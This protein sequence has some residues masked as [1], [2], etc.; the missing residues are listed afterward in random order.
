M[1]LNAPPGPSSDLGHIWD[2]QP[3]PLGPIRGLVERFRVARRVEIAYIAPG[4]LGPGKKK[5]RNTGN[6]VQGVPGSIPASRPTIPL[7]SEIPCRFPSERA[8]RTPQRWGRTSEE[9]SYVL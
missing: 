2:F 6:G 1:A 9:R 7:C 3:V 4:R 5:K 8:C